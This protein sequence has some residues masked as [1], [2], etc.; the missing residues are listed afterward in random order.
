M[1]PAAPTQVVAPAL[2][3]R[4]LREGAGEGAAVPWAVES[5]AHVEGLPPGCG[6]A[7]DALSELARGGGRWLATVTPGGP[8]APR[9]LARSE[10][11]YLLPQRPPSDLYVVRDGATARVLP[12][13]SLNA[14]RDEVPILGM[15]MRG[16]NAVEWWQEVRDAR[17]LVLAPSLPRV[18]R[19][20]ATIVALRCGL[21]LFSAEGRSRVE[22]ALTACERRSRGVYDASDWD[23]PPFTLV[24]ADR[25]FAETFNDDDETNGARYDATAAAVGAVFYVAGAISGGFAPGARGDDVATA[26]QRKDL[27]IAQRCEAA[28]YSM[29]LCAQYAPG[30]GQSLD[31]R[32]LDAREREF[33]R[34]LSV[35]SDAVRAVVGDA[36][37]IARAVETP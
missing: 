29:A 20:A 31:V 13:E 1:I 19:A 15:S 36:W 8:W 10:S 26:E 28:V 14:E 30:L 12:P 6:P 21:Y 2:R 32:E 11:E 24:P 5:F 34:W 23:Q 27:A 4:P 7:Y 16:V 18:V 37:F 9:E 33:Q 25:L 22:A 3:Y 17:W 35:A